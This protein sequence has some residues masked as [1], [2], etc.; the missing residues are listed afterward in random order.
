MK[1]AIVLVVFICSLTMILAG[2]YNTE[3]HARRLQASF[4]NIFLDGTGV[5]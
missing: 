5:N 1:K 3:R 2:C 4:T